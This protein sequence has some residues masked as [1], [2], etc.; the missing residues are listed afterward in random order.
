[1]TISASTLFEKRYLRVH[2]NGVEFMQTAVLAR[3]RRFAFSEISVVLLAADNTLSFQVG[4]EVFK[5]ATRRD[6]PQHREAIAALLSGVR[7]SAG[8]PTGQPLQ[9]AT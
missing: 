2:G 6:K 4:Q 7:A 9:F 1:M 5:I 3:K 8:M